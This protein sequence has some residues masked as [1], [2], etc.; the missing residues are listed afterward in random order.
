MARCQRHD[1]ADIEHIKKPNEGIPVMY[2]KNAE[3]QF[4]D[5]MTRLCTLPTWTEKQQTEL[6]MARDAALDMLRIA[7]SI[8]QGTAESDAPGRLLKHAKAV[9]FVLSMLASGQSIH[10]R[11]LRVVFRLAGLTIDDTYPG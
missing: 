3:Q 7:E 2:P 5:M 4:Q 9:E 10:P 6:Q 8:Q 11:T 1:Q